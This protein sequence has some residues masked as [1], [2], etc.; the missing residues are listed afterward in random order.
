MESRT[1]KETK[2][3]GDALACGDAIDSISWDLDTKRSGHISLETNR[4]LTADELQAVSAFVSDENKKGIGKRFM[5]QFAYY[6]TYNFNQTYKYVQ[7][8]INCDG[9]DFAFMAA[10]EKLEMPVSDN[11][12]YETSFELTHDLLEDEK[13]IRQTNGWIVRRNR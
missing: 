8:G 3:V 2:K 6:E 5:W 9:Q 1:E 12:V 10:S 4:D 13:W 7:A 11:Y